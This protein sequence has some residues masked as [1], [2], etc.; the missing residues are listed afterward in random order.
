VAWQTLGRYRPSNSPMTPHTFRRIAGCYVFL[1]VFSV[2]PAAQQ[3]HVPAETT[4]LIQVLNVGPNGTV[5][6][7]GAGEGE[8]T[9]ELARQLGPGSRIYS[10][11]VNDKTLAGLR[12]LVA[13]E[14]LTNV[15]VVKGE[16]D[17][18][19]LPESCCDALFVRHVYHH[20]GNP[21]AMNA[22]ILRT[23][24]PGGRFAVM[25]FPPRKPV[26]GPVPPAQRAS[27]DT[28]GVTIDTVVEELEAAGFRILDTA[29]DWP[30]GLFLVL[31]ERPQ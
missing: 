9:V 8:M 16:F 28:H 3:K 13:R 27:G 6:D 14:E 12:D 22:S 1:L 23:L 18:T 11:D 21:E 19:A 2:A 7:I 29:R 31:A 15:T 20:F 30:G 10:T 17:A 5:A 24:K 4:R 25:D 26:K